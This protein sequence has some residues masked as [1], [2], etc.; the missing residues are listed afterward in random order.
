MNEMEALASERKALANSVQRW[1]RSVVDLS[2]RVKVT[3][4]GSA[5]RASLR[6]ATAELDV[7]QGK[8]AA[9]DR[10]LLNSLSD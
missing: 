3:R 2:E 8:L 9:F 6:D 5:L 10:N 4:G 7:A 1:R